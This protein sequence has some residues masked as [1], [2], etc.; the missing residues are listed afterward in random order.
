MSV[1]MLYLDVEGVSYVVNIYL[2]ATCRYTTLRSEA[3]LCSEFTAISRM[4]HRYIW[5]LKGFVLGFMFH[6][7][8]QCFVERIKKQTC[9]SV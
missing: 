3:C 1:G 4:K 5:V 2:R 6:A 9:K 7:N 8:A